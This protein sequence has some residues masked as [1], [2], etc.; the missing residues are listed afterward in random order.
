[1]R[2]MLGTDGSRCVAAI[3]VVARSEMASWARECQG[4]ALPFLSLV[5]AE[6]VVSKADRLQFHD[7]CGD[8]PRI[9]I[10]REENDELREIPHEFGVRGVRQSIVQLNALPDELVVGSGHD[11]HGSLLAV[12]VVVI[13]LKLS[14]DVQ[15]VDLIDQRV[16]GLTMLRFRTR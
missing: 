8:Q 6:G 12:I 2:E 14:F 7:Q 9:L 15:S 4:R 10:P 1:M 3:R 11:E 5:D 16:D 13:E